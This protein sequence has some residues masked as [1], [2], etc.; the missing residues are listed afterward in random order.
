M[1]ASTR[2]IKRKGIYSF[3][4]LYLDVLK[5]PLTSHFQ[6]KP[7]FSSKACFSP[8]VTLPSTQ[9]SIPQTNLGVILD[10]CLSLISQVQF[11]TRSVG[12]TQPSFFLSQLSLSS[13]YLLW[14]SSGLLM[15]HLNCCSCSSALFLTRQ[16]WANFVSMCM[17][18]FRVKGCVPF[19]V[20][21][22]SLKKSKTTALIHHAYQ[23]PEKSVRTCYM[24]ASMVPSWSGSLISC[25]PNLS[26]YTKA[27]ST[28]YTVNIHFFS[29]AYIIS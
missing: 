8:W 3:L 29:F 15:S 1:R 19:S 21:L 16:L 27:H 25:H 6:T 23:L 17:Y 7:I 26:S 13:P 20:A 28:H 10:A 22:R 5:A 14:L 24:P 2:I 9:L 12:N 11:V 18:L 4:L